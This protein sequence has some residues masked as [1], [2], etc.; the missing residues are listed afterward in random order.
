MTGPGM[1]ELDRLKGSFLAIIS[2]ELRTPLTE[3]IAASSILGD[4]YLGELTDE[5]RHYLQIIEH[6]A[7]QLNKLIQDLLS[8]AQLQSDVIE[9]R[10]ESSEL[11]EIARAAV[12]LYRAPMQEKNLRLVLRLAPDLP[13]IAFDRLKVLRVFS[14]LMSNGVNFTPAGGRIMVRTRAVEGWQVFDVADTGVGIPKEKQAHIF[15]SFYQVEDPL[16]RRVGGLGIGLAYARRIVEA[17]RGRI[18]FESIEGKGS[19]FSVW[20]PAESANPENRAQ[21]A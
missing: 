19:L 12:D 17:H 13:P 18:T 7:E 4:G 16:I 21:Q 15:E 8:F 10:P 9:T 20:L 5:Q 1:N 11:N 3:I 2:H 6:S 14:N